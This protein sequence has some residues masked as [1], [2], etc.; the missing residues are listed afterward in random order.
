MQYALYAR[1][2]SAAALHDEDFD[3]ANDRLEMKRKV[4]WLRKKGYPDRIVDGTKTDGGKVFSPIPQLAVTVFK[5][6]KLRSGVRSGLLFQIDGKVISYRTI[7]HLYDR[8]LKA[9][10]L[11]FTATHLLRH[12]ALVEAY[13]VCRDILAVQNRANHKDLRATQKYA[14]VRDEKL[15]KTQRQM[16]KRTL[17]ILKM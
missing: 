6:W 5:E 11:P 9:A 13:N 2:Q 3:I 12:A 7:Q 10:G 15:Q 1:I 4:Q 17:L 8:A 16:D 14:K